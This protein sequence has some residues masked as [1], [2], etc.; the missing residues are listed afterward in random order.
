MKKLLMAAALVALV[1]NVFAEDDINEERWATPIEINLVSPL[2]LPWAERNVYGVRANILYGQSLDTFGLDFGL[3]GANRGNCYGLQLNCFNFIDGFFR[4]VE[5]APIGSFTTKIT[6]GLQI[7]GIVNWGLDDG[8]GVE[9]GCFNFSG[10][11][12]GIQAGLI[13]WD[14][15]LNTGLALGAINVGTADF[16]GGA[17]GLVNY[18]KGNLGGCQIGVFNMVFGH[19]NGLQ[20]GLFN[21]SDD[22]AGAQIGLLNLN[23]NGAL[24]I[25]AVINVNF[26]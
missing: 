26:R 1:G 23:A 2:G 18:C 9:L 19:S 7:A 4:G 6:Y 3:V 24:P 25:M 17:V 21:A 16:E 5:I 13:N 22:H 12:T 15:G 14:A 8:A 11:Y 10:A 20:V